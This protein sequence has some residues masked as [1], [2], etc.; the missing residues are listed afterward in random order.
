[1]RPRTIAG[2][3]LLGTALLSACGGSAGGY[4]TQA[5]TKAER[6]TSTVKVGKT[7]LGN[8]LVD[9]GGRTLYAFTDDTNGTST[10]TGTCAQNWPPLIVGA[11]WKSEAG[12]DRAILHTITR[13]DGR[14]QLVAG[15]WPLYRF[16][17]DSKPGDVTGQGIEKFVVVRP[18][19]TLITSA[20]STGTPTTTAPAPS[21]YGY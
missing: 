8:V 5:T 21:G 17:G 2:L 13:G 4:N 12:V 9:S 6:A 7:R 14:L 19:G 20:S 1:M 15:K 16:A 18:D 10:C 3:A 11:N